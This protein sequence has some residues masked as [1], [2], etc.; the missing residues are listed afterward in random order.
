[1]DELLTELRRHQRDF[2]SLIH[3]ELCG[4]AA[5][6]IERLR[7]KIED[8]LNPRLDKEAHFHQFIDRR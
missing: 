5:D 6:E 1:M 4:R 8:E 3:S 7:K 2:P